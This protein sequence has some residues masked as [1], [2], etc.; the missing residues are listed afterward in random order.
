MIMS[1]AHIKP[2][3]VGSMLVEGIVS[4]LALIAASSLLPLDYFIINVP[5][6]FLVS[7]IQFQ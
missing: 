6:P 1:E 4:V 7:Q 2:I 3:A 5:R